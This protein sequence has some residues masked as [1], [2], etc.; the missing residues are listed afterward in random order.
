MSDYVVTVPKHLWWDWIAEGDLPGDA[1]TGEDWAFYQGGS[2]PAEF[3]HGVHRDARLYVVAHG[4]LRG[5]APITRV[6]LTERGFAFCRG[7]AAVA[8]TIDE[9]IVGFRG[10]RKRW[11][12]RAI[13]QPF[14]SW[15]TAGVPR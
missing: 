4:R 1:P 10:Y 9:R 6:V 14:P 5:Y 2:P 13:E 11:W 3:T 8:C 7:G 12:D 15:Q